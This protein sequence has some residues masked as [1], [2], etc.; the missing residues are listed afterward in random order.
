MGI[1]PQPAHIKWPF[2]EKTAEGIEKN[3]RTLFQDTKQLSGVVPVELGGTGQ[4]DFDKGDIL[5]APLD[6]A[7]DGLAITATAGRFLRSNATL[8]EWSTLVLPNAAAQGDILYANAANALVTLAKNTSATRYLSNTGTSNNPA[9][10]QVDL[11]NGVTG[12]LP[13]GNGGTGSTSFTAGSILFSNGTIITQ[14][15][16][17]LF[18]N[19]TSNWL[20]IGTAA[21]TFP[22]DVRAG[23]DGRS[24][25]H[26]NDTS[27]DVGG[28]LTAIAASNI[29]ALTGGSAW[30][31]NWFANVSACAGVH[32][33][34]GSVK[35][36]ADSGLALS[37]ATHTPTVRGRIYPSGGAAFLGTIADP[38]AGIF[39]IGGTLQITT[40]LAVAYGGTG[41]ASH[42]AYAV[43]CGGTTGTGAQ[44]SIASVGSSGQVLTSNGA[45]ALP[46]FQNATGGGTVDEAFVMAVAGM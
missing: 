22:V 9:W 5:Y 12:T 16:A 25:I 2:D 38:G 28:Y 41:R 23:T 14:D 30:N 44:Q 13:V 11:T 7:V 40:P 26:F 46:T 15:N 37:P 18:W 35:F 4:T 24:P 21:P 29:V 43:L 34:A 36:V 10:A 39:N 17:A 45:G 6:G 42:T 8:P 32:I 20:G 19:N 33:D 1:R 31:G 3:F 27:A